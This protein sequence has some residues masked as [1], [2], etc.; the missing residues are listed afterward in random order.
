MSDRVGRELVHREIR[1][2]RENRLGA[3]S[4]RLLRT[5]C[6][7]FRFQRTG[8]SVHGLVALLCSDAGV[9]GDVEQHG[10]A[11]ALIAELG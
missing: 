9:A 3:Q 6:R 5:A 1:L 4:L 7:V 10:K 11:E 8:E 2:E